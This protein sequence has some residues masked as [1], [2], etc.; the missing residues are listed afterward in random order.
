MGS[1]RLVRTPSPF[2]QASE[3]SI[4]VAVAAAIGSSQNP[5]SP[6]LTPIQMMTLHATQSVLTVSSSAVGS[7][8]PTQ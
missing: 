1:E 8:K 5:S 6:M 7:R 3:R 2:H 4:R